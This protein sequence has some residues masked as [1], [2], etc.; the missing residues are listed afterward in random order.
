MK[1]IGNILYVLGIV[2]L[3]ATPALPIGVALFMG[4]EEAAGAGMLSMFTFWPGLICFFMGRS[5]RAPSTVAD[6]GTQPTSSSNSKKIVKALLIGVLIILILM[7]I[8]S[9]PSLLALFR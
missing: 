7:A 9:L 5:L 2:L 6:T 3:I 8:A 1:L 4:G